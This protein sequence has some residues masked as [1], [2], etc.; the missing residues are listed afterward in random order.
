MVAISGASYGG[1]DIEGLVDQYRSVETIPRSM[2]E[3]RKESLT[4]RKT[5]LTDLDS[6]LS[7]LY[8]LG[9]RFSDIILN[10]FNTKDAESSY[11]ELFT[12]T[13]GSDALAGSHD[14][15]ISRLAS[16]DTRV[17]Q[18]Y[19]STDSDFTAITTDQTFGVEVAHPTDADP[20]NR[21]EV[22]V[23]V[24]AATFAKTNEEALQ[25]IANAINEAMNT[26]ATADDIEAT[27]K[28]VATVVS[29]ETGVSRLVFRSGESGENYALQFNDT[30][31]LL[32]TLE[33]NA[34]SQSTGTSGGYIKAANELSALF[35]ID[36]L[37]F[38]RD[39]NYVDDALEGVNIQL[40]GETT[41]TESI[42]V[43]ADLE[44]VKQ[45]VQDFM[46]SY[47]EVVTFLNEQTDTE[48]EFR[49]DS[50]Y[51]TLKFE[52]RNIINAQ[53]T[54]VLS[55]DYD[56][57]HEIGIGVKR[58]GTLYFEDDEEFEAALSTNPQVVSDLF[59]ADD[60]IAV[61]LNDFIV[62][63]TRASGII[64][65][66]QKTVEASLRYQDTRIETFDERLEK[67]VERFR[68]DLLR[69]QTVF[70]EM[71]QQSSFF[72]NFSGGLGGG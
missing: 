53:V 49:G 1:L 23:T 54:N 33:V 32:A 37:S 31:G 29:E 28:A 11:P 12:V 64:S 5:A 57:L 55:S 15:E 66:S 40:F 2:L 62:R 7:A 42:T 46:D 26:S 71:Q 59:T 9:E 60:G 63:Y 56:R 61:V 25:D 3:V 45:E 21:V 24:S 51:S 43:T 27:E 22:T 34:G 17:S 8:T 30:D 6:K 69:L 52:L 70:L 68:Q 41:T 10:V 13:A 4:S 14:I 16:V 48:G 38:T 44:A 67:K 65:T 36:G 58:D 20:N 47:N 35:T 39:S 19:V 18:Q 50:T 72:T